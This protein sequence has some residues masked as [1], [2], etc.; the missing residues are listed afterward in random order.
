MLCEPAGSVTGVEGIIFNGVDEFSI[1]TDLY[2]DN[3]AQRRLAGI[4]TAVE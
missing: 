4:R 2:P 3:L 1:N